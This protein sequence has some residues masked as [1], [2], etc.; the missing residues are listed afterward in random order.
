MLNSNENI[1]VDAAKPDSACGI[2]DAPTR[3]AF[4][5]I[6]AHNGRLIAERQ[7]HHAHM[8]ELGGAIGEFLEAYFA[9]ERR[10]PNPPVKSGERIAHAIQ[11][12]GE[13]VPFQIPDEPEQLSMEATA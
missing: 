11:R 8:L 13:M 1:V 3:K 9:P 2:T 12:L 10:G 4:N 7:E 6:V 5:H